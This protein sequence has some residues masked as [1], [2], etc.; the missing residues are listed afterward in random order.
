[1]R[2]ELVKEQK[3]IAEDLAELERKKAEATRKAMTDEALYRELQE[4]GVELQRTRGYIGYWTQSTSPDAVLARVK[5]AIQAGRFDRLGSNG[6]ARPMEWTNRHEKLL[7]HMRE[8]KIPFDAR[9][10]STP[11]SQV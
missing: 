4:V 8:H 2:A 10:R 9:S 6:V 5:K 1:M 7:Q 11:F 3:A